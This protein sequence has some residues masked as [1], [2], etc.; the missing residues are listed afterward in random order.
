MS[1]ETGCIAPVNAD[2]RIITNF[3]V[4]PLGAATP[5]CGH[6]GAEPATFPPHSL[7]GTIAI[8]G[9]F[10]PTFNDGACARNKPNSRRLKWELPASTSVHI[11]SRQH[12]HAK[13]TISPTLDLER[14]SLPREDVRTARANSALV[15][16]HPM[17]TMIRAQGPVSLFHLETRRTFPIVRPSLRRSSRAY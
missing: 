12:A 5:Q 14:R 6:K 1:T 10:C 4:A 2:D 17:P 13:I 16:K 7:H 15:W 9:S 8:S 11:V 3:P